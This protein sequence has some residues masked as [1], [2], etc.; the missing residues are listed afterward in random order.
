[1]KKE[2]LEKI[3]KLHEAEKYQEIIDLIEGL[4]DK[5]LDA[6]LIGELGRAYNN[7]ENYQKGLEILKSIETEEGDNAL[8]NWR[9]GYSYYFLKDYINAKKHFLKAYE[10]D[11]D[12]EDVCDFLIGVYLSLAKI[13]DEKGNSEKALE[14]ALES[15]RYVKNEQVE[16]DTE[17]LIAWLYN[18]YMDYTKAE[19]ILRSILA[20]N[21]EDEWVLSELG[22]C[23]S[24]QEKHEEA[25]KFL[26]RLEKIGV[27]DSWTNTE[28]AY[29]LSKLNRYEEA[30]GKL[31]HALEVEDEEKETG[32]IYTQ[33]GLCNRN[34]EKYEEAIEAF[35]QAKKWGRNDAWINDEIGHCYKKKGDMKKALEFYLIAEKENKKDPYLMSDMAWIYDG[36]GQYEEGLKYIKKAV[37]LGRDDA[38]LNE[39]YGAC[40]AGLDRYEEAI[41]KYKYALNLDDEEKDEAYIYRQLGW[42]YRQLEDYEKALEYA[43]IAYELDKDDIHSLSQVGWF[44]DYMGKYEEG[45]PFLL[46]AEELGRD[47]EWINTE[48]AINLGRSGKTSEG[49]ERLHKS[50][51]MVSEEDINQRIFI[52]SEIAWNYGRLEEPHPEEALKYLNI[53]KELGREDAWIYSQIGYQ[54]GYNLETRKEALEHFDKALELGQN[55]AWIFEMRG[56]IL[57]DFKRYEEALDSFKKAYDLNDD[58]WYL[59]SMGECLR[60]LGRYQE[61]IEVLLESRQISIDEDDVVDGEDLELAHSYL[62]IGDKDNAQKYLD[63]AR[64]SLIEQGTLNDEIK[65]EIEKIEKGILSLEN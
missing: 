3:G 27:D 58:S 62:G 52:N 54:L 37:K 26:Q 17:S 1:M 24:E 49:I 44:Y 59:Y 18:K 39:E 28:Y 25:L 6:D 16:V 48:I 9:I 5:Q 60:K 22:Y 34:L 43:L 64:T 23:L 51:V 55:D 14:Y 2:L 45:L 15:R 57:L 36:L 63:S 11:P 7:V 32:Y 35:T 61:A 19:E 65:E 40:L 29:C 31:N 33:L 53:A 13:E 41:E 30:I 50:L 8:W 38:W 56:T 20:K 12:D 42:C 21:K 47:D 10:L 46:R 4:P